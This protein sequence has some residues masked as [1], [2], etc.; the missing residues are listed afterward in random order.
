MTNKVT[1]TVVNYAD[2]ISVDELMRSINHLNT[3]HIIDVIS[4][5]YAHASAKNL[6]CDTSDVLMFCKPRDV[7]EQM[8]K[9]TFVLETH[10]GG[11]QSPGLMA[12]GVIDTSF[13]SIAKHLVSTKTAPIKVE[14]PNDVI[15]S[16][17][18]CKLAQCYY[19]DY[20][21]EDNSVVINGRYEILH[22]FA[23][24]I[25][26]VTSKIYDLIGDKML[27]NNFR[28]VEKGQLYETVYLHPHHL[29]IIDLFDHLNAI[30]LLMDRIICLHNVHK[31]RNLVK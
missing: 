27:F 4:I 18:E 1:Q 19:R 9:K 14:L 28:V 24:M 6:M 29:I 13:D 26:R 15:F 12:G 11:K 31:N 3:E 16:K 7:A 5:H 23:Q 10:T 22:E 25:I 30:R 8:L 17:D 21:A 2:L 20:Y